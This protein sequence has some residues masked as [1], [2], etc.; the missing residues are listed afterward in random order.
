MSDLYI[1][2]SE[3]HQKIEQ[4]AAQVHQSDWKFN[5]I[6]CLAKGGLR[7]GDIL[8]RI[9]DLAAGDSSDLFLWRYWWTGARLDYHFAG[10]V[11]DD[12]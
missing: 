8:A 2:W 12:S 1:S 4:L 6:I 11:D 7:V 10:S 5:Q 3:Y 9:F